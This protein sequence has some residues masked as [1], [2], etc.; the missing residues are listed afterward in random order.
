MERDRKK[1]ADERLKESGDRW[2]KRMAELKDQLEEVKASS[3]SE[4]ELDY[5]EVET[6][7]L[8]EEF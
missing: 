3:Q 6:P 5:D 1:E 4:E 2:Y 7:P 8:E